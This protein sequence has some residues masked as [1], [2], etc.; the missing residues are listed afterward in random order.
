LAADQTSPF[1]IESEKKNL[2]YAESWALTHCLLR[3]GG[4]RPQFRQFVNALAQGQS[5]DESFKRSF[6]TDYA[7][8][9]QEMKNYIG[10]GVYPIE[11]TPCTQPLRYETESKA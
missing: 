1:S 11:E 5:V 3:A 8:I 6:Q 9:E 4:R 7:T 2:F 10:Q